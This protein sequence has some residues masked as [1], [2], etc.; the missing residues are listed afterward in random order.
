MDGR[1]FGYK[2]KFLQKGP[3]KCILGAKSGDKNF[4]APDKIPVLPEK[5]PAEK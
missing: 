4:C 1:H 5:V 3:L 2:Q